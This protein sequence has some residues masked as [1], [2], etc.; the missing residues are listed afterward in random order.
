MC[1]PDYVLRTTPEAFGRWSAP[2][3][4]RFSNVL[5][6]G[7]VEK[8]VFTCFLTVLMAFKHVFG[9]SPYK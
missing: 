9:P 2:Q 5:G 1:Y 7:Q 3:R 6:G 4:K 8:R